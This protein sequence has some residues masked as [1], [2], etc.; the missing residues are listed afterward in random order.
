MLEDDEI[1]SGVGV[2]VA[3]AAAEDED[4]PPEE[5]TVAEER[6][7]EAALPQDL[8]LFP[9][10][11]ELDELPSPRA[12]EALKVWY[13]RLR[14]LYAFIRT[15]G[16]CN[17]PQKYESN[18]PLG[19]WVNKQ[20]STRATLGRGKAAA[21]DAVGFDWGKK[22]GEQAWNTQ[23]DELVEYK[24]VHGDCKC[25]KSLRMRGVP[26]FDNSAHCIIRRSCSNEV[27]RKPRAW[28]LG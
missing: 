19:I 27:H 8:R 9:L 24:R 26:Q 16:N 25:H 22:K 6:E 28:S 18:P 23:Y 20:R 14:E 12:K 13:L 3:V 21:L 17:V 15:H 4:D 5:A 11:S 10:E 1:N 2:V 7:D